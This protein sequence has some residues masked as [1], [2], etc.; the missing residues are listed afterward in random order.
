MMQ[1]RM[2]E[3]WKPG[4]NNSV[5]WMANSVMQVSPRR[6]DLFHSLLSPIP[7]AV[8]A[9][10]SPALSAGDRTSTAQ[11]PNTTTS[12]TDAVFRNSFRPEV[13]KRGM[14]TRTPNA[15]PLTAR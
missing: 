5:G 14:A 8:V 9:A 4:F 1:P 13:M 7:S 10:I 15:N 3:S 2:N 12:I 11:R 6:L